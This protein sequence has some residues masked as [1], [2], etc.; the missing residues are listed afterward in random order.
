VSAMA[1]RARAR[2]LAQLI[3]EVKDAARADEMLGWFEAQL[4]AMDGRQA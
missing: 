3:G 1:D 2:T 4:A